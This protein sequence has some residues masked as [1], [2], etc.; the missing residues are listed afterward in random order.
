MCYNIRIFLCVLFIS[1]CSDDPAV[2]HVEDHSQHDEVGSIPNEIEPDVEIKLPGTKISQLIG[3]YDRHKNQPTHNLTNTRY[4]LQATDLGVP[5]QHNGKIFIL[6]GDTWGA[7]GGFLNSIAYTTDTN[8]EVSLELNFIICDDDIYQPLT[9]P[10]IS[11]GIYE[12]PTGGVS[13]DDK[14]YIYHTTDH[15][16]EKTMG[17]SVVAKSE[18]EG[19]SFNMLYSLSS[20]N[21]INVSVVKFYGND[22]SDQYEII[23]ENDEDI[24]FLFGSGS[25]RESNVYL[26]HKPASKIENSES[27]RY[28][29]GVDGNHNPL[30]SSKE[31]NSV[32]LFQQPCVGELSVTYNSFISRWI[33][34]Y[35]CDEP[36]GINIRTSTFPWGPWSAPQVL[37][38]PWDD[39]GYCNFIHTNWDYRQ[40]D[41][42]HD[43]G[44]EY[45]WGGEYGP[46]QFAEYATGNDQSTT[47]YFTMSTWNPYTVV[48]MK[49]ELQIMQN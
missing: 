44:R 28:F 2:T 23:S 5:L 31:K 34:L 22:W 16:A 49:S 11:Q 7:R 35:N 37:F 3:D 4:Q 10:G 17:R 47:I 38:H 9:I 13:I 19:K 46:Y 26:A 24:L 40:C 45:E 12:V 21:F 43:S 42:V 48:L 30:W 32:P 25:Y 29:A 36:R 27:I 1:N 15:S 33:M 6:F 41:H 14:M 20:L 18:N 8:P 39:D